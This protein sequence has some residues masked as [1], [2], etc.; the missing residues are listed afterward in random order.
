M[1][2]PDGVPVLGVRDH[3]PAAVRGL[4]RIA[5]RVSPPLT[6]AGVG[7]WTDQRGGPLVLDN[8]D[9]CGV[10]VRDASAD[11]VLLGDGTAVTA[12]NDRYVRQPDARFAAAREISVFRVASGKPPVL[13]RSARAAVASCLATRTGAN[14]GAARGL[15]PRVMFGAAINDDTS[16]RAVAYLL[17]RL[18]R[19]L[20][21]AESPDILSAILAE[22]AAL[23]FRVHVRL[24]PSAG[25]LTSGPEDRRS[26]SAGSVGAS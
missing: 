12:S 26:M 1:S 5:R 3:R 4:T 2:D 24:G 17:A 21:D 10:C 18:L 13:D 19:D 25:H 20:A 23:I 8:A 11:A 16:P 15:G 7:T 9:S 14:A 6:P 22:I